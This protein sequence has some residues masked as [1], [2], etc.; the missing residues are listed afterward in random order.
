MGWLYWAV[1]T[2]IGSCLG[3]IHVC[4]LYSLTALLISSTCIKL[5]LPLTVMAGIDWIVA[6]IA[7]TIVCILEHLDLLSLFRLLP[8]LCIALYNRCTWRHL[9]LC[10]NYLVYVLI[11]CLTIPMWHSWITTRTRWPTLDCIVISRRLISCFLMVAL[12]SWISLL[13]WNNWLWVLSLLKLIALCTSRFII[14][15]RY[16][17]DPKI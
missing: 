9:V 12:I 11:C 1:P 7:T 16:I 10:S 2:D 4:Q 8:D 15:P 5:L 14:S 17:I 3:F 6:R 13:V